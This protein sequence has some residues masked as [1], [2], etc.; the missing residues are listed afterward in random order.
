VRD[1]VVALVRDHLKPGA[2]YEVR[3]QVSA[4]A[5]RRLARRVEADLLYRVARADCLGRTGD[6]PPLAMEWFIGEVRGLS[7]ERPGPEPLLKGRDILELGV[8]PGPPVGRILAEVYEQQLDS[9]VQ[10]REEALAA[11]RRL[12]TAL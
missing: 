6:F 11:A 1:Q 10:T 7:V 4:G 2:L 3:E 9:K 8:K 5:I 12:V